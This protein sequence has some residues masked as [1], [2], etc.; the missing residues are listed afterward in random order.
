[1]RIYDKADHIPNNFIC[2]TRKTIKKDIVAHGHNFFEIEYFISGDGTHEID[3]VA[4]PLRPNSLFLLSPAAVHSISS[5][6]AELITVMF[7]C[8]YDGEFFIF[9]QI[10][11]TYS[12]AFYLDCANADVLPPLLHELLATHETDTRYALLLLRCILHKLTALRDPCL[13]EP[14]P[15]IQNVIL[16]IL[17]N[18]RGEI[19]LEKTAL[20]FGFSKAY[21]SDLFLRQTGVNFKSYLDEIRF[22]HVKNLLSSTDLPIGEIYPRAGFFDYANFARRFKQKYGMTPTDYRFKTALPK[23]KTVKT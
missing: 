20:H 21:F 10:S 8:E 6:N 5:P 2:V 14:L 9:P 18:F 4:Y 22:S 16:Y 1:M 19:T 7:Q 3:G 13:G 12:P 15:M 17:E 23:N 11:P